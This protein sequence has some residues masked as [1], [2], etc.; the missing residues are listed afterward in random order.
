M[1][2]LIP[3]K[4]PLDLQTPE[5]CFYPHQK[6]W[7]SGSSVRGSYSLGTSLQKNILCPTPSTETLETWDQ[8]PQSSKHSSWH[9]WSPEPW[10]CLYLKENQTHQLPP[11]AQ[12]CRHLEEKRAPKSQAPP[13]E[14]EAKGLPM[15]R[16][17]L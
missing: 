6:R 9:L 3:N 2:W 16:P 14:L 8:L 7:V 17:H 12:T 1:R 13:A 4:L 11:E 10:P 15:H 5:P